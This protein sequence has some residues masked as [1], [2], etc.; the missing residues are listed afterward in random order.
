MNASRIIGA[1]LCGTLALCAENPTIE[2]SAYAAGV[3]AARALAPRVPEGK[4]ILVFRTHIDAYDSEAAENAFIQTILAEY[5]RIPL[6]STDYHSG[7]TLASAE[8]IARGLL[9]KHAKS[10]GGVF[11]AGDQSARGA[12]RALL[13][14][15]PRTPMAV[16]LN[17]HAQ[18][19]ALRGEY[20]D[21]DVFCSDAPPLRATDTAF[22]ALQK[23]PPKTPYTPTPRGRTIPEINLE[24]VGLPGVHVAIDNTGKRTQAVIDAFYIGRFEVTQAQWQAVME[25]NPSVFKDPQRPVDNI[26]WDDA[27]RFCKALT[28]R[29]RA[30]GRIGPNESFTLPTRAQWIYAAKAGGQEPNGAALDAV[31]W[32]RNTSG[33]PVIDG[34]ER[35]MSTQPIGTRASNA[36]GLFDMYGN[37]LEWCIDDLPQNSFSQYD[38]RYHPL[39]G[40][41]W[42]TDPENCRADAGHKA[43]AAR[44]HSALGFRVV[45]NEARPR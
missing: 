19:L 27:V 13:D 7:E 42:W 9:T 45:L 40:G 5:P 22:I 34:S 16:F 31:A 44:H 38:P 10:L 1:F 18:A 35:P 36:F 29:E 2:P 8:R 4:G 12:L 41:G 33:R 15:A 37:V 43:P 24:L 25:D 6:L 14:S 20:P 11:A 28:Q 30:A 17:E 39:Q 32:Q 26:S 3:A 21:V 23:P